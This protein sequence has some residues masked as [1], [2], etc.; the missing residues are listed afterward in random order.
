MRQTINRCMALALA[1]ILMAAAATAQTTSGSL[2]GIVRDSQAAGVP[3]VTVTLT[4]NQRG[5]QATVVTQEGG[6]F[7]FPQ[8]QPGS[9]TLKVALE[10]FKTV[11]RTNVGGTPNH[12]PHTVP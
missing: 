3:G 2:A 11:D 8:V 10:G 1:A 5:D 6:V 12:N 7:T 4:N 9:Y